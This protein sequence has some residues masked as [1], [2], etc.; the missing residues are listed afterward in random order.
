MKWKLLLYRGII[1]GI[2]RGHGKY[3]GNYYSGFRVKLF[4]GIEVQSVKCDYDL[5]VPTI[6]PWLHQKDKI[7]RKPRLLKTLK[8]FK[9]GLCA[10][11]RFHSLPCGAGI[12]HPEIGSDKRSREWGQRRQWEGLLC[13]V[14][15]IM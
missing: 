10:L 1:W 4:R 7:L 12:E 2:Y 15:G 6:A 11:V 3:N 5:Q 13:N 14:T 9:S 8:P